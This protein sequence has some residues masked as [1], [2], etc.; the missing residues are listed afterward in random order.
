[1]YTISK[2]FYFSASHKLHKLPESHPCGRI[3]GHNYVVIVHLK[4]KEL[5]DEGFVKDYR[6]LQLIKEYI[7]KEWD[8]RHLNSLLLHPTA[9]NIAELF[10]NVCKNGFRMKQVYAVTVKET[11][12]T[13]ATYCE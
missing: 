2:E 7:D 3:H 4:S 1:M 12:K 10:Y 11:D 13:E 9:E 8:H 6:E 5:D